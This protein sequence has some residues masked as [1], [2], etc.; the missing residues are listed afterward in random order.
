MTPRKVRRKS[1]QA[2]RNP[3]GKW[4]FAV[5]AASL[6]PLV[7]LLPACF[8][9]IWGI[10]EFKKKAGR[11]LLALGLSGFLFTDILAACYHGQMFPLCLISKAFGGSSL[12]SGTIDWQQ[13]AQGQALSQQSRKPILYAFTAHWCGYCKRMR[14]NVFENT[15]DAS[16]INESYVPVAVWDAKQ[17][18]GQNPPEV[19]DL[20]AKYHV[21][22]FPTLVVQ[23]PDNGPATQMTGFVSE[24]AVMN[25]INRIN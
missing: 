17:E 4:H 18:Q 1:N 25:F 2:P 21:T 23:Y 10:P 22:G 12:G 9:I 5:G 20:Q 19:A 3:I 11:V 7:G 8:S 24:A 14:E 16:K 6:I 15:Q 13:P